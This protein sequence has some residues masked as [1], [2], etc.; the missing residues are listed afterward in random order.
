[1]IADVQFSQEDAV[2]KSFIKLKCIVSFN[3]FLF[4]YYS[5]F[6][7]CCWRYNISGKVWNHLLCRQF[8][9]KCVKFRLVRLGLMGAWSIRVNRIQTIIASQQFHEILASVRVHR[10]VLMASMTFATNTIQLAA[11]AVILTDAVRQPFHSH[12]FPSFTLNVFQNAYTIRST[13]FSMRYGSSG[14]KFR[15]IFSVVITLYC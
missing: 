4:W 12:T 10:I 11:V 1:M 3:Y 14:D 15:V 7:V 9:R 6:G 8:T 5:M 13:V 2:S